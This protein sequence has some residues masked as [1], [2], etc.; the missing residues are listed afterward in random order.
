MFISSL[1][2]E[3]D[4]P[5]TDDEYLMKTNALYTESFASSQLLPGVEK[6]IRHLAAHH[7]PIGKLKNSQKNILF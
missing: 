1:T 3:L 5:I 4:L 2:G 6:L 7:I